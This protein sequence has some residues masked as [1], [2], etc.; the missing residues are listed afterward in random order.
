VGKVAI[1]RGM[2]E[3]DGIDLFIRDTKTEG[4]AILCLHG[5]WGR[6]ETW[7]DF[8]NR[9]GDRYRVIAPDLRGHGLSGKPIARY[10]AELMSEDIVRLL[11]RLG[12]NSAIIVGHSMGGHVAGCLAARYPNCTR[13]AAILDKSASGP[14]RGSAP[15]PEELHVEDPVTK[16]WKLPF[17]SLSEAQATIRESMDSELGYQYFMNSLVETV[18]GY[19][20]MFSSQAVAA[21]IA[22]Y[23]DWY[24]LLPR[25]TCP[26]M[27]LRAKGGE[28]VS[29]EDFARMRA[30]IPR[31]RAYELSNPDHNV[32][33]ADK[34]EFYGCFDDFLGHAFPAIPS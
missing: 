31:C 4:P 12:I 32:H 9:Y 30:A 29:D 11:R 22:S 5:R 6:G 21:N 17:P 13:A 28:A 23:Q 10:T 26:V 3:L 27:L 2:I 25:I 19:S 20:M 15:P 34:D 1:H 18:E 8:M 24:E 33:L 16:D 7:V 14:A